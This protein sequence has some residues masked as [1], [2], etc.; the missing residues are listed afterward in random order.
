MQKSISLQPDMQTQDL[1]TFYQQ[2]IEHFSENLTAANRLFNRLSIVRVGIMLALAGCLY[3]YIRTNDGFFW[4]IIIA[5]LSGLFIITVRKHLQAGQQKRWQQTLRQINQDEQQF[6]HRRQQPRETGSQFADPHHDF[7]HDLDIFGEN[8]LYRY[9]VRAGTYMGK[10]RLARMLQEILPHDSVLQNQAA[11]QDLSSHIELRHLVHAGALLADDNEL[12]VKNLIQW[13]GQSVEQPAGWVRIAMYLLPVVFMLLLLM[14]IFS[15]ES[16][17]SQLAFSSFL[18]NLAVAGTQRKLILHELSSFDRV[19]QTLQRYSDIFTRIETTDF[20]ADLLK[21]LQ[22]QLQHTD[23]S[24]SVLTVRLSRLTTF[25]ETIYN[26]MAAILLNG[27][28]LFHLHTFNRLLTW[29]K[30]YAAYLPQWLEVIAQ[31]EALGSWGNF[32]FNHPRFVFPQL[33]QAY[34]IQF[35]ALGHPLLAPEKRID[36][37]VDFN[38]YPLVILTGS[39]MSGKSTFLRALGMNML[40]AGIG[41][42]VCSTAANVHPLPILVSMRLSDSLADGESYFFSEIKRL[43]HIMDTLQEKACFVLLD[44]ILRGTNSEDKQNGTMGV[45]RHLLGKKAIGVVATHD[46]EVC[47][48]AMEYPE[49]LTNKCFEVSIANGQLH[50]DF[51]LRDGICRN[52]SATYLMQQMGII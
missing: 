6:I 30:Q 3:T 26:P 42:P 4:W 20:K 15:N 45:I 32:T 38:Q 11:I 19:S 9:V 14:S 12:I 50:F 44:E 37:T 48:L 28:C 27:T 22:Q 52:K 33:N 34:K 10:Q 43:K 49:N 8:S 2:R 40:L 23:A 17:Y 29:K 35:E 31:V 5:L 39:N 16:M 47:N 1:P 7:S 18:L 46:L 13:S 21:R 51:I 36:N 41:A 24:A 25:A